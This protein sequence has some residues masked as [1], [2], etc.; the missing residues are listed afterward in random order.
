MMADYLTRAD[1]ARL[2]AGGANRVKQNQDLLCRLDSVTGDGDHGLTMRRTADAMLESLAGAEAQAAGP[3]LDS[4]AW[5]VMSVDGGSASPLW[6]SF[7]LGMAEAA[8]AGQ[9]WDAAG[10]SA[11]WTAG[12]DKLCQ[13]TPAKVGDKTMLDALAPAVESFGRA[14]RS[15][16]G[17]RHALAAA[18]EAAAQGAESTKAMQARFGRA[19]NLGARTIGHVDPGATSVALLW[20]GFR[21]SLD[22]P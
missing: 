8:G 15:G 18:A 11:L 22:T 20:A 3:L 10:L 21:D 5:S 19:R 13:Q 9:Q 1:L 12:L 6:G 17:L 7:F 2:L 14:A 16:L 4:L